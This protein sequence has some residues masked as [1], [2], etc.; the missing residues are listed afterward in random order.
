MYSLIGHPAD[1]LRRDTDGEV[2]WFA[3]LHLLQSIGLFKCEKLMR[4][5]L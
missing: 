5:S 2:R 4:G 3:R 1:S